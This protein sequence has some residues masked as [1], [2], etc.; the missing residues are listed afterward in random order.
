MENEGTGT[1][2]ERS[3]NR[4]GALYYFILKKNLRKFS[5]SQ[6]MNTFPIQ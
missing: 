2:I 1:L 6:K 3:D 4:F 5:T